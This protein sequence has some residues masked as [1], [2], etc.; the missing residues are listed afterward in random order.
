M[1]EARWGEGDNRAAV[2]PEIAAQKHTRRI[3]L[4]VIMNMNIAIMC[5]HP[6]K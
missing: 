4:L 1:A 5:S 6:V 3:F 2:S